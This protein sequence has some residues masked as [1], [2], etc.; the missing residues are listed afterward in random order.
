MKKILILGVDFVTFIVMCQVSRS[1]K[2]I[3]KEKAIVFVRKHLLNSEGL[4]DLIIVFA[5][6]VI[7]KSIDLPMIK[8]RYGSPEMKIIIISD[9][10]ESLD[11]V[12]K[13][14]SADLYLPAYLFAGEVDEDTKNSLLA[15]V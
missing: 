14:A 1:L 15:L 4:I 11:E 9:T 5:N 12:K 2:K 7:N 8:Q 10:N 13:V 6:E 3:L